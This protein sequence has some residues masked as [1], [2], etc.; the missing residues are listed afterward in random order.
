MAFMVR[1]SNHSR[2]K[3]TNLIQILPVHTGE[4]MWGAIHSDSYYEAN[5]TLIAK[6]HK[7]STKKFYKLIS[8]I[9]INEKNPT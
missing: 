9:N 7:D 8:P 6:S 2:K 4:N 5:I 3:Y 1:S